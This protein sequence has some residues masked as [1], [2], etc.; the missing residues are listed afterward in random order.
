MSAKYHLLKAREK[1]IRSCSP[2]DSWNVGLTAQCQLKHIGT[3]QT[4][5]PGHN[6]RT[7]WTC[8]VACIVEDGA[9]CVP[10]VAHSGEYVPPPGEPIPPSPLGK[11][12]SDLQALH[13]HSLAR[14]G[15][16]RRA[17]S[18]VLQP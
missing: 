14:R 5:G 16:F 6:T 2:R 1:G 10:A 4:C 8:R 9:S 13:R 15:S 12:T 11:S 17:W 18:C 3:V 7:S